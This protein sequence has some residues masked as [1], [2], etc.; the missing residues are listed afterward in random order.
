MSNKKMMFWMAVFVAWM[1]TGSQAYDYGDR[2]DM[3]WLMA[4]ALVWISG[5][6][7]WSGYSRLRKEKVEFLIT[8]FTEVKPEHRAML[9]LYNQWEQSLE[10]MEKQGVNLIKNV[11]AKDRLIASVEA[12]VLFNRNYLAN[13]AAMPA[14][15]ADAQLAVSNSH[16]CLFHLKNLADIREANALQQELETNTPPAAASSRPAGRL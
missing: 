2:H 1:L 12:D 13:I 10:M 9:R 15:E 16:A 4:A 7:I 14:T 6:L 3:T 11:D 8:N 5:P